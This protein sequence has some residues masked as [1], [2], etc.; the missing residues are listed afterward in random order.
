MP[1]PLVPISADRQRPSGF[2]DIGGGC[3]RGENE[4]TQPAAGSPTSWPQHHGLTNGTW[5]QNTLLEV[6][7]QWCPF[8]LLN[9]EPRRR[10]SV[11]CDSSA[12][13]WILAESRR[14]QGLHLLLPVRQLRL[15]EAKPLWYGHTVARSH[16]DRVTQRQGHT[17]TRSHRPFG[18]S[19]E[20]NTEPLVLGLEV[21]KS[22]CPPCPLPIFRIVWH[23]GTRCWNLPNLLLLFGPQCLKLSDG[24]MYC[25]C[26]QVAVRSDS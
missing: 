25:P 5:W 10:K 14:Q 15:R 23:H 18:M 13:P 20:Q 17:A 12:S 1:W 6:P 22:H 19:A 3:E 7:V 4:L 9:C 2:R 26:P 8:V 24:D 16:S 21:W 11:C